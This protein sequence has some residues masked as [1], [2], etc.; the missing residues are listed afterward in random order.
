MNRWGLPIGNGRYVRAFL[1]A[2]Q[3]RIAQFPRGR[4]RGEVGLKEEGEGMRF[5]SWMQLLRD[6]QFNKQITADLPAFSFTLHP[7]APLSL[8]PLNPE[9][10]LVTF[11]Q[12]MKPSS[13]VGLDALLHVAG[14]RLRVSIALSAFK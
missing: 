10:L 2:T 9:N 12:R 3:R 8:R 1:W 6:R 5:C 14:K 11:F 4:G 7:S 13:F